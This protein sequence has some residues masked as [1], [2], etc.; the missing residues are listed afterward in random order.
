MCCNTNRLCSCVMRHFSRYAADGLRQVTVGQITRWL[1]RS[2]R[3]KRR[4]TSDLLET[5]VLK[6]MRHPAFRRFKTLY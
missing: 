1:S 6:D 5:V 4:W 2:P 3:E